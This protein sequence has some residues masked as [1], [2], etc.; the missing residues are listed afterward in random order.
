MLTVKFEVKRS[1]FP[2][3]NKLLRCAGLA[4]GIS[5]NGVSEITEILE[6]T[7]KD[8]SEIAV[9]KTKLNIKRALEKLGYDCYSIERI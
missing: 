2:F 3:I 5:V 8:G 4:K 6:I 9:E 7:W 1:P